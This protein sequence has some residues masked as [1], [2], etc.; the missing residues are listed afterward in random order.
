MRRSQTLC[1]KARTTM[2]LEKMAPKW[3]LFGTWALAIGGQT[4]FSLRSKWNE[5]VQHVFIVMKQCEHTFSL[6]HVLVASEEARPTEAH[7]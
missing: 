6:A 2:F 7:I 5:G 4:H 1:G 3:A